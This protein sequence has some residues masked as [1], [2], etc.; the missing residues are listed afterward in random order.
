MQDEGIRPEI[1]MAK[2][3]VGSGIAGLIF[4]TGS[5]MI[6]LIGIP[7]LRFMLPAAVVLGSG[8]AVMF[9]FVRHEKQSTSR[10]FPM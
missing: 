2:I 10:I 6:F 9:H 8:V 3:R 4:A 1:D 7:A 5:T